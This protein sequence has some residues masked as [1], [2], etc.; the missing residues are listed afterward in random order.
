MPES[1][2]QVLPAFA[3]LD[4]LVDFFDTHDL[5][6]HLDQMPEAH[7]DVNLRRTTWLLAV[8][9]EVVRRVAEIARQE[10][11]PPEALVN[12]WLQER[13]SSYPDPA[14]G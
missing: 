11:M 7:F 5:G 4:E 8:D 3:S 6:D 13:I 2:Q 10:Q 1:N 12:R 9:E 14:R